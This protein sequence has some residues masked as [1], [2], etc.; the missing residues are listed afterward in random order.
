LYQYAGNDPLNYTDANGASPVLAAVG[1]AVGQLAIE[2]AIM[3]AITGDA[4]SA[5]LATAALQAA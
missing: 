2:G 1:L 5:L 3:Y 4:P